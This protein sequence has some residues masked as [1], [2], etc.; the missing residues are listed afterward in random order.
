MSVLEARIAPVPTGSWQLDP[1]HSHVGFEVPYLVG[2]FK[3]QFRD[4]QARLTVGD[5]DATLE[6]PAN[7]DS[8]DAKDEN[9]SPHPQSPDFFEAER[10]PDLR[11]SA[12]EIALDGDNV[13]ARGELEIKGV[14]RP[15]T[16]AGTLTPPMVDA[17]GNERIG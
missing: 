3:G 11:F 7:D 14:T 17:Y 12:R 8:A 16:V 13:E 2:T 5:T 4:V 1:V 15:V 6:G 9:L 10:Y